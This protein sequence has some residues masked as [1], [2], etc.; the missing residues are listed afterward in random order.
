MELRDIRYFA[1]I[2]EHQNIGRAADALGLSATALSKS[3]RRLEAN[4]GAKLVQRAPKGVALTAVGMA[5]L[6]RTSPL[7]GMLNDVQHEA[8]DL[9]RG[10]AGHIHIGAGTGAPEHLIGNA[11]IELTQ[12]FPDI[13]LKV[14]SENPEVLRNAML[15]GEIDFCISIAQLFPPSEFAFETLYDDQIVVFASSNHR[16]AKLSRIA[17]SDIATERWV[18]I[19]NTPWK[20]SLRRMFEA[21]GLQSPS[22]VL[23]TNSEAI[24][25]FAIA[26]S[27]Y[28]GIASRQFL[29]QEAKRF[30]LAELPIKEMSDI[31]RVAIIYRR[32]AYLSPVAKRLIE[33]LKSQ[34]GNLLDSKHTRAIGRKK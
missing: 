6:S 5:L 3:L 24:R 21:G 22:L 29:H 16:L 33:I 15:R 10:H 19:T 28:L 27:N 11:C 8:A 14:F 20:H 1:A 34:A 12:G 31:R 32:G 2:A 23:D 7:Q 18:L 26:Y 30:P 4:L 13:T 17:L 9:A 25:I